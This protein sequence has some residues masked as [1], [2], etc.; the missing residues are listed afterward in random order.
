M[1][2]LSA[3]GQQQLLM[4][5]LV[6]TRLSLMLMAM[7][8]IGGGVPI[9]I[10]AMFAL[11]L[12]ALLLPLLGDLPPP[13]INNLVDLSIALARE[14]IVGILIGL[15]VQLLITGMQMAGELITATSNVQTGSVADP[16]LNTAMPVISNLVG[17]MV[18]VVLF[19]VGGHHMMFDA[20]ITSFR[21][22]PP[23]TVRVD[24]GWVELLVYELTQG[25]ATGVRA[26]TPVVTA[27]LLSNLITGLLSRTL[28]QL[29]ILAIGLNINSLAMLSVT[30]VALGSAAFLFEPQLDRAFDHLGQLLADIKQ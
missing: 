29:N 20:L 16:T 1:E 30:A 18:T 19:A 9:R 11:S 8:G 25:M 10:K 12:S 14:A 7:P 4:F 23:G 21:N 24:A 28:P 3:L 5:M 26:G 15:V 27:L 22:I 6:L 2:P 17:M 13:A